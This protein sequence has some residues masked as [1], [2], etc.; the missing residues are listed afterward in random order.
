MAVLISAPLISLTGPLESAHA[1][2]ADAE[3]MDTYV[4]PLNADTPDL[5]ELLQPA[6]LDTLRQSARAQASQPVLPHETT[7]P[8]RSYAPLSAYDSARAAPS[9]VGERSA[10]GDPVSGP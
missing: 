10:A 6:G 4:L 7:G 3:Q 1:T 5:S 8:A 2:S 9:P